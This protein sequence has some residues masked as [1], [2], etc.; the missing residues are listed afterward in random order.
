[1][2]FIQGSSS[3]PEMT[4]MNRIKRTSQNTDPLSGQK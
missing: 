2:R 4:A 1:M 3:H